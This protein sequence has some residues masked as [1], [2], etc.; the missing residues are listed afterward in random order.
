MNKGFLHPWSC[1][2]C[3]LVRVAG[4]AD[5][6]WPCR[7]SM[8]RPPRR[9]DS[10]SL[11][12]TKHLYHEIAAAFNLGRMLE[13]GEPA[14]GCPCI[15]CTGVIPPSPDGH[16]RRGSPSDGAK[17]AAQSVDIVEVLRKL[18]CDPRRK[19]QRW[20]AR[21]PLHDDTNPSMSV[22]TKQGLWYCFPCNVGGDAIELWM[23]AKNVDFKT[24]LRDL[25]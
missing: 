2:Q 20:V 19:S 3:S 9:T 11:D 16:F 7:T 17:R 24:T 23:L 4:I 12:P 13:V 15:R 18:G 6:C 10:P 8:S 14:P 25:S 5:T 22:D 1:T 21:C